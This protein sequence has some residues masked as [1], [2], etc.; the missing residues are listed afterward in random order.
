MIIVGGESFVTEYC[1]PLDKVKA[2]KGESM[3]F[4]IDFR[5]QFLDGDWKAIGDMPEDTK[6]GMISHYYK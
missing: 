6:N 1:T 3:L 5:Q 4:D 2:S